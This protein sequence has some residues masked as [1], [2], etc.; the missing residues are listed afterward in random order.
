MFADY[1][2]QV[3]QAYQEMKKG[4]QLSLNLMGSTPARLRA[5]CMAV[6][7]ARY[8]RKDE[9]TLRLF[10][11]QKEDPNAYMQ[12]IRHFEAD[13]FK[14]LDNFLKG[15]TSDTDHKNIE[16]LAWLIGF[17]PRPYRFTIDKP[18]PMQTDTR[19]PLS[20]ENKEEE[21]TATLQGAGDGDLKSGPAEQA[22]EKVTAPHHLLAPANRPFD[23]ADASR[24]PSNS[25]IRNR[26]LL[27]LVTGL[28]SVGIYLALHRKSPGQIR[29]LLL[30][31]QESCMYWTG[32]RY[33]QTSCKQRRGDT[34]VIA[35]DQERLNHL[36]R[37]TEP[38]TLTE[39]SLGKTWYSYINGNMEFF[40][41]D[42]FHPEYPDRKLR[43]VTRSI[44][45]KYSKKSE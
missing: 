31:G 39:N 35:L 18:E 22:D 10:F 27:A 44:L 21:Q 7:N 19:V 33:Q 6:L 23:H 28:I 11:G 8:E 42:G 13:K 29:P 40:T 24:I 37:I 5:E 3:V 16:L 2:L 45:L 25:R 26:V 15:I 17:E 34:L 30:S 12:T 14:P 4:N 1:K 9:P 38:D 43:R 41:A 36:M 20:S 32:D